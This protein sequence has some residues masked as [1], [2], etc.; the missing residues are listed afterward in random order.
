LKRTVKQE[1]EATLKVLQPALAE[2]KTGHAPLIEIT[3]SKQQKLQP[4]SPPVVGLCDYRRNRQPTGGSN[5]HL[6][7]FNF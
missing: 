2:N 4:L 7:T 3:I 5:F 6:S 1:I